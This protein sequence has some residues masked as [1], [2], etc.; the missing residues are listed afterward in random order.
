M[1]STFS[2]GAAIAVWFQL[3]DWHFWLGF[4]CVK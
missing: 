3:Y 2:G 1:N 4:R